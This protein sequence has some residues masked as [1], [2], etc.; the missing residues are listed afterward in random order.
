M[1][2]DVHPGFEYKFFVLSK[3]NVGNVEAKPGKIVS[4]NVITAVGDIAQNESV[5]IYPNPAIKSFTVNVQTK[6]PGEIGISVFDIHGRKISEIS[7]L[8]AGNNALIP[9]K[10]HNPSPGMYIVK[11]QTG[12]NEF[13]EKIMIQ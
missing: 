13:C 6:T 4:T 2:I 11:I 8:N 3:D 12:N 9:V 1:K 5:R 7:E 10:L